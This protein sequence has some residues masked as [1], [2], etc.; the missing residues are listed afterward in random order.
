[1]T[2]YRGFGGTNREVKQQF[3]GLGGVNRE[4]KEVYRGLSG[5]NRQVFQL[6]IPRPSGTNVLMHFNGNAVNE[7]AGSSVSGSPTGYITGKFSQAATG[8]A[9][10]ISGS[11]IVNYVADALYTLHFWLK[12]L[13]SF[14]SVKPIVDI[15]GLLKLEFI[16]AN[17]V[18][19]TAYYYDNSESKM[20]TRTWADISLP[21]GTWSHLAICNTSAENYTRKR[22]FLNGVIS[23]EYRNLYAQQGRYSQIV[24]YPNDGID[25]FYWN[26][27]ACLW[28]SN[29]TPPTAPYI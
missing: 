3:R 27:N 11:S 13:A 1:M 16:G 19:L 12:P 17:A 21:A 9:I 26:N 6:G 2:I 8:G 4:I 22:Y 15:Y 18:R 23:A 20:E 5:V 7:I 25:E 14:S 29:F 10:T 28:T 24:I